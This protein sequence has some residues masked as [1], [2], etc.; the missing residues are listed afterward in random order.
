MLERVLAEFLIMKKLLLLVAALILL[1]GTNSNVSGQTLSLFTW[2]NNGNNERIAD[3]GPNATTSGANAEA[4]PTGN[5]TPQGLAPGTFTSSPGGICCVFNCDP[6]CVTPNNCGFEN[7]N[8]VLP[9]P[10]G[11]FDQPELRFSIDYRRTNGET[12]AYFYT[13]EPTSGSGPRFR[14]GLQFSKF[15]VEFSTLNGGVNVNHDL[16]VFGFFGGLDDVPNDGAW[17]NFAFEYFQSTGM[18]YLY[19]DGVPAVTYFAG[20]AG[21]PMN[22]PATLLSIAPN[23]DNEGDDTAIFDNSEISVPIVL[24]VTYNYVTGEQVGVRT[25]IDWET[26][27]ESNSSHYNVLRATPEGEFE[28]IGTVGAAGT[29]AD[30]TQYTFF[31]NNPQPGTNFYRLEQVD[32]NGATAL[33]QVVEVQ[34]DL[35]DLGLV[36][37][38]PNPVRSDQLLNVK[39]RAGEERSLRLVIADLQGRILRDQEFEVTQEIMNL[40]IPMYDLPT[41]MYIARVVAGGKAYT[42]KFTKQ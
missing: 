14:M 20:Q 16:T 21:A 25:R 7:I 3:I 29:T 28:D 1:V 15:K 39:F 17:R 2:D 33:S 32:L 30:A 22:W 36:A 9:N 35:D 34:F 27:V 18:A 23:C 37:V 26:M 38:Y 12:E 42:Q 13:R 31:D 41:G 8:M 19:V 24:P 10:S 5:G 4:Q 40:E 6:C 11:Y